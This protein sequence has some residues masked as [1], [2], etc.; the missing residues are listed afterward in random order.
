METFKKDKTVEM[1]L[2][3]A[4]NHFQFATINL[5]FVDMGSQELNAAIRLAE[6]KK[7]I[8]L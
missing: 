7:G 4:R 3:K 2:E 6:S 5:N 8:Q 1:L